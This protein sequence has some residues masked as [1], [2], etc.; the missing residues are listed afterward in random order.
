MKNWMNRA[1]FLALSTA[2]VLILSSVLSSTSKT[3]DYSD[4][5]PAAVCPP[6][7]NG[8]TAAVSTPSIHSPYH[9]VRGR[10]LRDREIKTLRL[11]TGSTPI[12][13]D[14]QSVTPLMWQNRVGTWAGGVPCQA[15]QASQWFVGGSADITSRGSLVI[16]N[17]GLSAALVDL[18]VWSEAGPQPMKTISVAASGTQ[19]LKLDSLAPGAARTA[20]H[21]SPRSGRINA[22]LV[23][24]RGKGLRALGGDLVNSA[25]NSDK[26]IV[27][28]GI[29]Q[30]S[31]EKVKKSK[32]K[33]AISQSHT[34]RVLVPGEVDAR[35]SV[36]VISSDGIFN[37]I[38]FSARIAK[39][40]VVNDYVFDPNLG[41]G[42]FAIRIKADQKIVASV[43][44]S[45]KSLSGRTDFVW[46]T[47]T[48]ELKEFTIATTGL[49][50]VITFSGERISLSIR[51]LFTNGKV[52][53]FKVKGSD[54]ATWRA[55]ANT[56]SLSFQKVGKNI[57]AGALQTSASGTA[58]YPMVPGS[59]ITRTA[60]PRSN[61]RVLN[62]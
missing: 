27:I 57:Y 28:A 31:Q 24:E 12:V 55:P 1:S 60:I 29:P 58:F 22:F 19:I 20:F 35:I 50:P 7:L 38:G 49:A 14:A 26:E 18:H 23:D 9:L 52:Q 34:L 36:E 17:S 8:V 16:V 44:S 21:V 51:A 59:Q 47:R 46:S 32:G 37:P 53:T 61:I 48:T 62:P 39:A 43:Q 11:T 6:A 45:I 40:G 10:S 25:S 13:I 4:N 33:G 5:Y 41:S 56:R 3:G 15:P 30:A 54:L 42:N 2:V